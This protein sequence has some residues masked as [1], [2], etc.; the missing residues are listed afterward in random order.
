MHVSTFN[1]CF[2]QA[3]VKG[4]D[5]LYGLTHTARAIGVAHDLFLASPRYNNPDN[6]QIAIVVTDGL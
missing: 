3:A 4:I 2:S 5:Y 6:R 1:F